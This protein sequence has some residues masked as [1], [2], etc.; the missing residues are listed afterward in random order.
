MTYFRTKDGQIKLAQTAKYRG[1]F[2]DDEENVINIISPTT[3][4]LVY[5]RDHALSVKYQ[6]EIYFVY[7]T[8]LSGRCDI[9]GIHL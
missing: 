5:A 4:L 7:S 9:C 6:C 8:G 3:S 2:T 1:G